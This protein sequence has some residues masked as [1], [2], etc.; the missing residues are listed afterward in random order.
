MSGV[1]G[2]GPSFDARVRTVTS[3][4][5]SQ[6]QHDFA[7]LLGREMTRPGASSANPEQR[8]RTAAEDFVATSLV[9]PLLKSVREANQ[10]PAPWGPSDVEK[11]FGGLM[12]ADRARQ[13]VRS[14]S[15]GIVDRLA[16]DLLQR[17]V[18]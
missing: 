4:Q 11:S 13:I 1:A 10:A 8:A 5:T 3:S 6:R 2:I 16:R 12:D 17:P 15:F 18:G 9:E 7:A 14:S